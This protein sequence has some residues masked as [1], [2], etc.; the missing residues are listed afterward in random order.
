[1]PALGPNA[2]L[3]ALVVSQEAEV[4]A[5]AA[6]PSECEAGCTHHRPVRRSCAKL[7]KRVFEIHMKHCPNR[8]GQLKIIAVMLKAPVI[9]K[10]LTRVGLQARAPPLA[11]ARGQALPAA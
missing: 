5:Q 10:I 9:E 6:P 4:P 3:R 11:P 7:L 2:K 8:G 1:M